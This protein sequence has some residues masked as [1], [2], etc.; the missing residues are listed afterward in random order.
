[1]ERGFRS[2]LKS[3]EPMTV[4]RLISF[5]VP[6][7][8]IKEPDPSYVQLMSVDQAVEQKLKTLVQ[9]TYAAD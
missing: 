9:L 2:V 8:E 3:D 6:V 4:A 5:T 1:M 7:I